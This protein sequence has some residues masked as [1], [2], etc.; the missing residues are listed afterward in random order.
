MIVDISVAYEQNEIISKELIILQD[1]FKNPEI[2]TGIRSAI[3]EVYFQ[4]FKKLRQIYVISLNLA[5]KS[6]HVSESTLRYKEIDDSLTIE[7][8]GSFDTETI[9]DFLQ[10]EIVNTIFS[11]GFLRINIINP[12]TGF[13]KIISE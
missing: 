13:K 2:T 11:L 7:M 10:P 3:S 9:N 4:F 5:L 1:L 6:G 12:E 8:L